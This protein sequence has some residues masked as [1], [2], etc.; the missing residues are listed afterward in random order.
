MPG[1]SCRFG[2]PQIFFW[3]PTRCQELCQ[4]LHFYITL[5]S[6]LRR[7]D[8]GTI[9]QIWKLRLREE[10]SLAQRVTL[11]FFSGLIGDCTLAFAGFKVLALIAPPH[12]QETPGV[13]Y[14]RTVNLGWNVH[15]VWSPLPG[16]AGDIR[17]EGALPGRSLSLHVEQ[18][19][20][21]GLCVC[22][23]DD[24]HF[25]AVWL[26]ASYYTSLTLCH[27][28]WIKDNSMY[29][30]EVVVRTNELIHA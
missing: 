1:T 17:E 19:L 16:M 8:D 20:T 9:S 23:P 5:H 3:P 7:Q 12:R 24:D 27:H 6:K 26:Q 29:L 2:L 10:K 30:V 18:F 15:G 11:I 28:A 13:S 4:V 22:K 21:V 14:C 25:S